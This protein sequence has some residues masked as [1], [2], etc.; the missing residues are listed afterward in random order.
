L[1]DCRVFACGRGASAADGYAQRLQDVS[2]GIASSSPGSVR[3]ISRTVAAT[4]AVFGIGRDFSFVVV[5]AP[6]P[7]T[8]RLNENRLARLEFRW[9]EQLLT[10]AAA[11]LTHS[12]VVASDANREI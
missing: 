6:P 10:V 3:A 9:L 1:Q 7:L 11:P 5:G 4:L 2:G 8:I 12:A